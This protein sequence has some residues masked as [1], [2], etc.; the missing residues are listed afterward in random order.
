[1]KF[2]LGKIL[3]SMNRSFCEEGATE[4]SEVYYDTG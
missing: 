2:R 3:F 1:M 4:M